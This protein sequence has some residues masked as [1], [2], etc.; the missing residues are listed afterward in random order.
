MTDTDAPELTVTDIDLLSAEVRCYP[1]VDRP[2][3]VSVRD[4]PLLNRPPWVRTIGKLG[5]DIT[6]QGWRHRL[7][8]N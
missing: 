1:A 6:T 7:P 3:A 4:V 5:F 8:A 2:P